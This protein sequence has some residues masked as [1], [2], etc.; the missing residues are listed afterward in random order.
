MARYST[1]YRPAGKPGEFHGTVGTTTVGDCSAHWFTVRGNIVAQAYYEQG[2]RF[3]DVS[4]PANP[5]QTGWARVPARAA[6]AGRPRD[7]LE[8]HVGRLLARRLRLRLGLRARRRH[9][10]VH[11]SDPGR[12]SRSETPLGSAL[13]FAS[14][15][16]STEAQRAPA[17]Q[18]TPLRSDARASA[19]CRL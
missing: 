13:G 4:D 16:R 11:D 3:I 18:T 10:P 14:F 17:Q 1:F 19:L 9:L 5:V 12:S 6:A 7:R 15:L 2:V 8:Q